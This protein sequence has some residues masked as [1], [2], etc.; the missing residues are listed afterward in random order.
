MGLT[1]PSTSRN[2]RAN[3]VRKQ[4]I[5]FLYYSSFSYRRY[6]YCIQVATELAKLYCIYLETLFVQLLSVDPILLAVIFLLMNFMILMYWH[7]IVYSGT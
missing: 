6:S 2:L 1:L 5:S 3:K 4:N 7:V